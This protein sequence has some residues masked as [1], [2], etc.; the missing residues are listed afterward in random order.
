MC[1]TIYLWIAEICVCVSPYS[2]CLTSIYVCVCVCV[3]VCV[4]VCVYHILHMCNVWCAISCAHYALYIICHVHIAWYIMTWDIVN[5]MI[6]YDMVYM[7]L[8]I[9]YIMSLYI[10]IL[11]SDRYVQ[12]DVHST[13]ANHIAQHS[14]MLHSTVL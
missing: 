3:C 13:A 14:N 4:W 11:T 1:H 6:Y 10:M 5:I 12:Y 7:S 9:I 8:Y 2:S